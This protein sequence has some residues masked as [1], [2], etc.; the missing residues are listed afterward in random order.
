MAIQVITAAIGRYRRLVRDEENGVRPTHRPREWKRRER[1]LAKQNKRS[2]W[3]SK[4]SGLVLAPLI[5]DPVTGNM[6]DKMRSVCSKFEES[7][8]IRVQVYPRAGKS[9]KLDA[10]PE[11]L[12]WER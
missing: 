3:H 11:P 2:N 9:V 6:L 8:G 10:K 5:V 7:H 1:R 12:G 4:G